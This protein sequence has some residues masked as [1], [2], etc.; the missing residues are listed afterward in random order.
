VSEKPKPP[1]EPPGT[2]VPEP[3]ESGERDEQGRSRAERAADEA[4]V[5]PELRDLS[6]RHPRP[7][8]KPPPASH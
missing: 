1:D 3:T 8:E 6:R 5:T 4:E 7:G 2:E